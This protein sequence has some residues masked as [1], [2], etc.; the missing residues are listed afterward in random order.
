MFEECSVCGKR[1][2]PW[3][4]KVPDTLYN[5]WIADWSKKMYGV[6]QNHYEC[7]MK[8]YRKYLN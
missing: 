8:K 1:I 4:R 6:P 7:N 2:M 3:Q 5:T